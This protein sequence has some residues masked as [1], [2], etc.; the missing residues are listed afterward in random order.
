MKQKLLIVISF[1]V[2]LLMVWC[3]NNKTQTLHGFYQSENVDGHFI[4]ISFQREDNTFVQYIDNIE[5]N[6]GMYEHLEDNIYMLKGDKKD[7]KIN[8][9]DD[10]FNISIDK[11]NDG[12]SIKIKK[13][14]NTPSYFESEFSDSERE[15]IENLFN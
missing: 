4:Q 3:T 6:K 5:V 13:V 14:G 11:L 12:K 9:E 1:L 10:F 7:L 15:K 2:I 8:L